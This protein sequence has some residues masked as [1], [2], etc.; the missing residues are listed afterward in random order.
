M[1]RDAGHQAGQV[2]V[3]MLGALPP[4]RG[5]SA[6]TV[7]LVQALAA[8]TDVVVEFLDFSALYPR[9]LYPGRDP[10]DTAQG[11]PELPNVA[12]SRTLAWYNPLSWIWVGLTFKGS[13]LH[14]QWWSYVLAPVYLTIMALARFRGRRV[15]LTLHNARPHEPGRVKRWLNEAVLRFAEHFIVHA[16]ANVEAL[17]DVY[18]AADRR[19]SVV[20]LGA[21]CGERRVPISQMEARKRLGLPVEGTIFLAFGNIR[22]YKGVDV[23]LRSV[24]QIIDAGY[25][26]TVAIAGEPWGSFDVYQGIID[27]L[28]LNQNVWTSLEYQDDERVEL[29]F[30]ACDIAVFPYK[31]FDAQSGAASVAIGFGLPLIVTDV[32]G[33]PDLVDDRRA[34]AQAGD[35]RSLA[36]ALCLVLDSPDLRDK[37]ASGS[38]RRA[39]ELNWDGIAAGTTDVY[40]AML[41]DRLASAA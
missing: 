17:L 39:G 34:I 27:D 3:S 8:R 6:F 32:G 40:R 19:I 28:E 20:P 36:E 2:H 30:M 11:R 10:K 12:V 33:L 4:W 38:R 7:Q 13:V 24:R 9:R 18:P 22:P 14:V 15:L 29:L 1:R 31:D 26:V 25:D 41:S 37:L 5:V 35:D 23:L 16:N 21:L